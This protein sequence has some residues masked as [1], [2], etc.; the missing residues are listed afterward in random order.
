MEKT[1]E[2]RVGSSW[3]SK[4]SWC[5]CGARYGHKIMKIEKEEGKEYCRVGDVIC[6]SCG[7]KA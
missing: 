3:R 1:A 6:P 5:K 4:D 7:R 2:E